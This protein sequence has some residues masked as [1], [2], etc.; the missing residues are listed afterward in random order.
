MCIVFAS[1][2]LIR[3]AGDLFSSSLLRRGAAVVPHVHLAPILM[4][5]DAGNNSSI[6]SIGGA[7]RLRLEPEHFLRMVEA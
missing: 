2:V 4:G 7:S 5:S 6:G 3:S 1:L